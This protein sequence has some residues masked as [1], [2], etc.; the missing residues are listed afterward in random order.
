MSAARTQV[1]RSL[2]FLFA[3]ISRLARKEFDR[4]VRDL[5]L[6]RAQWL[7]LYYLSRQPGCTQ[8][9]LA[10]LLQMEK[11]TISRQAKRLENAGW[12]ARGDHSEDAR[13]YRL[14]LTPRAGRIISRLEQRAAR[15]RNDYLDGISPPRRST[16]LADLTLIKANLVRLEGR[17]R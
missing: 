9:D 12:I 6:T 2:G 7:F 8:S 3:D 14:A 4:R 10:E 11:I 1:E 17:A 13:A 15:L 16:L 5:G